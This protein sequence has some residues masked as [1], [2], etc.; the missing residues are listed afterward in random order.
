[1]PARAP[2]ATSR[3]QRGAL[4]ERTAER[5]LRRAG[6]IVLARNWRGGGGELDRVVLDGETIVFVEVKSR[7]AGFLDD[8]R[9]VSRAQQRRIGAAARAFRS[10]YAVRHHPFRFDL[11][12]VSGDPRRPDHV[13]WTRGATAPTGDAPSKP[14]EST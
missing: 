13:E 11:V 1:M 14:S 7:H 6:H 3:R 12:S 8:R 10:R 9:P 2:T 5:T 4:A